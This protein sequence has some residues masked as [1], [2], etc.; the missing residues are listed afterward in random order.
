MDLLDLYRSPM[1]L[2]AKLIGMI[3][4]HRLSTVM[5]ADSVAYPF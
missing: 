2:S 5:S 4:D 3:S 1:R